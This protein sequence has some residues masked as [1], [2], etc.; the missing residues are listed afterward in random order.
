MFA[1][2]DAT[3]WRVRQCTKTH[4]TKTVQI[5]RGTSLDA[6][7]EEGLC[8]LDRA[9]LEQQLNVCVGCSVCYSFRNK[10]IQYET[11]CC[12]FDGI[13]AAESDGS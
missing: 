13:L 9:V 3:R 2:T 12:Y 4:L 10:D 6:R 5:D 11:M 1:F 8:L 7:D